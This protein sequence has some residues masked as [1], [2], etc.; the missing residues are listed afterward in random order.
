MRGLRDDKL[1][2]ALGEVQVKLLVG[3]STETR[4]DR[5]RRFILICQL[6]TL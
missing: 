6:S 2:T 1:I 4:Q 5:R 3:T